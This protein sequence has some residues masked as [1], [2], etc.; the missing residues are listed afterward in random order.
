MVLCIYV[1]LHPL[2][3]TP[4]SQVAAVGQAG[5]VGAAVLYPNRALTP[6]G[7]LTT[8][9]A[10]VCKYGYAASVRNVPVKEKAAVYEEYGLT[11]PQAPGGYEVDHFIA[12]ELGG[13]NDLQN[14]WPEPAE[15][16]PGFHEKDEIENYLH[17][18]VCSGR[19][20]LLNAQ[21]EIV[22]DWYAVYTRTH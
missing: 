21:H 14:L 1:A 12:L 15:P 11:Y 17:T 18:Q 7:V 19:M 13:S 3:H 20:S 22:S 8:D 4:T 6:G 2:T 9:S 16:R 5:H 10:V